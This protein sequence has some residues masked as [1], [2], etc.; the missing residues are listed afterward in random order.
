[1]YMIVRRRRRSKRKHTG[2]GGVL[3]DAALEIL[4]DVKGRPNHRGILAETI[5]LGHGDVGGAEGLDDA[6]LALDLVG[7]LRDELAGGLLAQ[8][9]AV[10]GGQGGE[11]VGWVGLAVAKLLHVEGRGDVGHVGL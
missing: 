1:M 6:V 9:V 7:R 2:H 5:R 4:H 10:A 3:K 8:D 11:E